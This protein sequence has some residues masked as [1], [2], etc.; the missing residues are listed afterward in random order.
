MKE[1]SEKE[2][3]VLIHAGEVILGV[4]REKLEER[5]IEEIDSYLVGLPPWIKSQIHLLLRMFNLRLTSFFLMLKF[6]PFTKMNLQEKQRFIEKWAYSRIPLLRSGM[7]GLKSLCAW[8]YYSQEEH[9]KDFDFPG[10]PL[11]QE[12]KVPTLLYGKQPWKPPT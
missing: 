12:D 6:E 5:Y 3:E 8:G 4:S 1:L 10:P 9:W 7:T 2:S 11:G